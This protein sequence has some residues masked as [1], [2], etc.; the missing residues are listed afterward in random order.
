M[1]GIYKTTTIACARAHTHTHTHTHAHAHAHTHT[2]AHRHAPV[3][4][5]GLC[6]WRPLV[7][8]A[9]INSIGHTAPIA[10]L[11]R[12]VC[13]ARRDQQQAGRQELQHG[14]RVGAAL[15]KAGQAAAG[16]AHAVCRGQVLQLRHRHQ[17]KLLH[18]RPLVR[19]ELMQQARQPRSNCAAQGHAGGRG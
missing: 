18:T 12:A 5:A 15:L 13:R 6:R 14:D 16:E 19:G 10:A 8:V 7:A 1:H 11:A 3:R 9:S 17:H 2:H 4:R